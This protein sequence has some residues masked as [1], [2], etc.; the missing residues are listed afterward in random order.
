MNRPILHI[1]IACL[2]DRNGRVL[3][4]RKRGTRY[5]MLPGGKV[6]GAETPLATLARELHEE[7]GMHIEAEAFDGLGEFEAPAAN[8]PG[9]WVMAKAF[10]APL[11]QT[12]EPLAEI[13]ELAWLD[14]H[15]PTPGYPLAPLLREQLLPKLRAVPAL[16]DA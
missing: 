12:V 9:H 14:P 10:I 15:A 13:E 4:V 6:E 2:Y 8:E 7:L 1:V 5:F 16:A 11:Q 3:V